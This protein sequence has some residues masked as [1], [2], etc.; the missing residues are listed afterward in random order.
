MVPRI[1]R[2]LGRV[3]KELR[4]FVS[5]P[6]P[7]VD[8]ISQIV[9]PYKTVVHSSEDAVPKD[10]LQDNPPQIVQIALDDAVYLFRVWISP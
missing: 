1:R 2:D 5:V 10:G 7:Y 8:N 6:H 4:Q 9:S 3:P